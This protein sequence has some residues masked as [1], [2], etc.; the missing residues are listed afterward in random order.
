[1]H[2]QV[3]EA[4]VELSIGHLDGQLLE[5]VRVLGVKVEPHLTEP[6]EGF[7]A[8]YFVLQQLTGHITLMHKFSDLSKYR[9]VSIHKLMQNLT[10]SYRVPTKPWK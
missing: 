9:V 2:S 4:I 8:G 7:G 1:M 5:W 3:L 10:D 6:V